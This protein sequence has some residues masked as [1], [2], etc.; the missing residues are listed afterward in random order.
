MPRRGFSRRRLGRRYR[1]KHWM[2]GGIGKRR[3]KRTR[4]PAHALAIGGYDPVALV[5]VEL[6]RA[7]GLSAAAPSKLARPAARRFLT[8]S[9]SPL[10]PTKA[11]PFEGER[12]HR[13]ADQAAG[14]PTHNGER[15]TSQADRDRIHHVAHHEARADVGPWPAIC[16]G[17]RIP[18]P[19]VTS[20]ASAPGPGRRRCRWPSP[21][22]LTSH[23]SP[24]REA[25]P[26]PRAGS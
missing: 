8:Q 18:S 17:Q 2:I 7:E 26:G 23:G 15:G 21:R 1:P 11:S 25:T 6:H 22:S 12:G 3:E 4:P 24:L 16:G 20:R 19:V 9:V 14:S 13:R 5:A 10:P